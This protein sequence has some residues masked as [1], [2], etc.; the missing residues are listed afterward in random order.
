MV[1]VPYDIIMVRTTVIDGA[2][3]YEGIPEK[4][5]KAVLVCNWIKSFVV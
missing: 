5:I 1:V 4:A 3:Q 2:N